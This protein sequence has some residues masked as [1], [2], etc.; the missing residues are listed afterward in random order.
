MIFYIL[1]WIF[2]QNYGSSYENLW[3]KGAKNMP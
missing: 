3:E 1:I 2:G